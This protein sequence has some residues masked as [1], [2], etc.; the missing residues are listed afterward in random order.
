MVYRKNIE[1]FFTNIDRP[2]FGLKLPQEVAAALF[3]RYSRSYGSLRSIFE[4]EFLGDDAIVG[5]EELLENAKEKAE[6]FHDRVLSAYGDDSVAQLGG[7]QVA[8]EN[9]SGIAALFLTDFRTGVAFLEKSTRYVRFDKKDESGN[10]PYY[11][12]EVLADMPEYR[13]TMDVLFNVYSHQITSTIE[14]LKNNYP[15]EK[16]NI[17]NPETGEERLGNEWEGEWVRKAYLSAL[18]SKAL[19]IL[20]SYPVSYTHLTLPTNREV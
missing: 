4:N 11:V 20:R 14:W 19:D 12:P 1:H 3:A 13:E 9:I 8:C 2:I 15:L 17:R 7:A 5:N 6:R 10:Y 16:I 18:R